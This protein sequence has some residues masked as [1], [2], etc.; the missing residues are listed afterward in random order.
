MFIKIICIA[1]LLEFS[2]SEYDAIIMPMSKDSKYG[3][4]IC[5][6]TNKEIHYVKPC[7]QGKYC[8]TSNSIKTIDYA[9]G[10]DVYEDS[11][12]YI[13]R[14]LPKISSIFTYG[15]SGCKNDFEC[16]GGYKCIENVCSYDECPTGTFYSY[17]S[18]YGVSCK[19]NS[20]KGSDD[21]VCEEH[22]IDTNGRNEYKYSPPKPNKIC[23][24]LTLVNDPN[25]NEKG[26]YYIQKKEYVY[27]G[28]VEDGEFV[29]QANLCKS[30][31]ALYFF[32]D[33]KTE[34]PRDSNANTANNI[35]YLMCVTPIS[36]NNINSGKC[37]I[38]YKINENGE[39]LSYSVYKLSNFNSNLPSGG[40]S[41]V[42]DYCTSTTMSANDRLFI[43][44]KSEKYREFYTKITEEERKTCGD[45]DNA[46]KY[47][48]ENNELIKLWYF[49]K[50][51]ADYLNYNDR[52][53]I[54]NVLNYNIQSR[55]PCYSLSQFLSIK[56]I[57]LLILLLF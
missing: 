26:I 39:I 6:Y 2:L 15:E 42:S 19:L 35:M 55:Y 9:R 53:K 25:D 8:D 40:F 24:K 10:K 5:Y 34:D 44:L 28:E 51:P 32:K 47:T 36:I 57:Y 56:F 33:G 27:K 45:L 46:N 7:E 12:I 4:D 48:C 21:G 18:L 49:Y 17:D 54:G 37:T 14:D 29:T 38:N 31:F 22:I 23:G 43:K 41:V 16:E 20:E 52:K 13:C 50:Y 3:D 11:S 30:N 1:A